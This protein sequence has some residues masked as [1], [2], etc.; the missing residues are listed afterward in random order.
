M[1]KGIWCAY[2]HEILLSDTQVEKET[3]WKQTL[4]HRAVKAG[5]DDGGRE[6][7]VGG[8]N[9]PAP[10][11]SAPGSALKAW[12]L[13]RSPRSVSL[14]SITSDPKTLRRGMWIAISSGFKLAGNISSLV[15][16]ITD[17]DPNTQVCTLGFILAKNIKQRQGK[18]RK[19]PL[20]PLNE[21]NRSPMLSGSR[22]IH[23][24][25][26]VG[27]VALL[28]DAGKRKTRWDSSPGVP[29]Q[30]CSS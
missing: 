18:G 3:Y 20:W 30:P 11:E 16:D 28:R 19:T 14:G 9:S 8:T 26:P 17:Q 10:T 7:G 27:H 1:Q 12:L 15:K 4:T 24:S 5:G 22:S 13:P 2:S 25:T 6:D 29:P 21:G 23:S